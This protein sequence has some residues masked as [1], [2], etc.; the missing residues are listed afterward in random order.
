MFAPSVLWLD[1]WRRATALGWTTL[2]RLAALPA[3]AQ[4]RNWWLADMRL[5]S[6]DLLKSP[7]FLALMRSNLALL[8]NHTLPTFQKATRMIAP[9]R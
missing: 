6:A 2:Q 1:W 5:A 3:P 9:P 8:T 7:A 4:F